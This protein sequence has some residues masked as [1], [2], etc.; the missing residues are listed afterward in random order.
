MPN[1]GKKNPKMKGPKRVQ[2]KIQKHRTGK[3]KYPAITPGTGRA[4]SRAFGSG[5]SKQTAAGARHC[6]NALHPSHLAL[7][8]PVGPYTVVRLTTTFSTN[9]PFVMIGTF[10]H[11]S[12]DNKRPDMSSGH[13]GAYFSYEEEWSSVCALSA[14]ANNMNTPIAG[15]QSDHTNYTGGHSDV[16]HFSMYTQSGLDNLRSNCQITPSALTVQVMNATSLQT[17]SGLMYAAVVP[18]EANYSTHH[19]GATANEIGQ[20][21]ISFMKPRLLSLPKLALGG[22]CAHSHPLDMNDIS[23][24]REIGN[25]TD[26]GVKITNP[27]TYFWGRPHAGTLDSTYSNKAANISTC[28]WAPI[29]FYRPDAISPETGPNAV[30]HDT[31]TFQVTTEYRVRFDLSNVAS[32]THKLHTPAPMTT[33]T[34]MIKNAVGALP[35]I[36][37]NVAEI[38]GGSAIAK[39]GMLA[40]AA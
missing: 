3:S 34:N 13:S 14:S 11:A 16:A 25:T 29:M 12:S 1:T 5:S 24:F 40:L 31:L 39:K 21:M 23:D 32:A 17:T 7:P 4:V 2:K 20:N 37:E 35:G 28:G 38:A 10:K 22:V 15:Y 18:L 6:W 9:D 27:G 26:G 19:G 30:A 33:Y 36:L 8:R